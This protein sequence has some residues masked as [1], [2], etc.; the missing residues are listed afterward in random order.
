MKTEVLTVGQV[1][2]VLY[3]DDAPRAFLFLHGQCGYKEEAA[4]L[5]ETAVPLGWQVLGVDL[6]Q[7][8]GRTDGARLLPWDVVPELQAV[9]DNMQSR[10]RHIALHATSIGAYF[11]L[12][13]LQERPLER[14]LLVSP[15]LDMQAMI[16]GMMAQAGVTEAQLAE[17]KDVETGFGPTLSWDYLCWARQHPVTPLCADTRIL[18]GER[19]GMI[20]RQT[21]DAFTSQ[22]G[23]R[24]TV[25][26]ECEHWFHTPGQLRFLR[27]WQQQQLEANLT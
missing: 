5:A 8:G 12:T 21:V 19:D 6:P 18:Y 10:W 26:P 2:A 20:S 23:C 27:F 11:G 22:Y 13:A 16:A 25:M 24:L 7:H 15:L 4:F 3:G 9:M 1:P 14:C 17:K